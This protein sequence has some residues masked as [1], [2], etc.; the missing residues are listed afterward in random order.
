M[1]FEADKLCSIPYF[2]S[3]PA[4]RQHSSNPP[5]PEAEQLIPHGQVEDVVGLQGRLR[6][7][8]ELTRSPITSKNPAYSTTTKS[9][10]P[11]LKMLETQRHLLQAYEY[12]CHVGEL[13]VIVT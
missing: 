2:S 7:T 9:S 8:R 4:R 6:L 12:L 10:L 13:V 11:S 1:R 5:H 3:G